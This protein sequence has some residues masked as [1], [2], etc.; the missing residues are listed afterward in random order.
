[1]EKV[2]N[3]SQLL[4]L[5]KEDVKNC[6]EKKIAFLAGHFPLFY[7]KE[8]KLAIE[9]ISHW[10]QF[11][12][13]TLELACEVAEYAKTIG[14]KIEFIFFV[15]D[16]AYEE[17][18]QLQPRE[19][20]SRRDKLYK[21]RS[22]LNAGLPSEYMN[23]MVKYGF[24]EKDVLRHDHNKTGRHDCLY[25]SEKILRA[26]KKQIENA[27]AREYTE[28]LDDMKYFNNKDTYLIAFIPNRCQG[29]ICDVALTNQPNLR[30]SHVFMETMAPNASGAELF[31]TNRGVTYQKC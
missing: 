4:D 5:L 19:L 7:N 29:H 14:K 15:D 25:F 2:N 18:S 20:S 24:S 22:G 12:T 27:C 21:L 11:S 9:A 28:F 17:L 23:I 13:Y 16:H 6:Y 3:Q 1:M 8:S 31:E 30:A 26:S 10:G